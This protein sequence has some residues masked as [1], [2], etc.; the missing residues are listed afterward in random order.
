MHVLVTVTS[1]NKQTEITIALISERLCNNVIAQQN[2]FP[3]PISTTA[4][5][6]PNFKIA[7]SLWFLLAM[8]QGSVQIRRNRAGRGA[9]N[10][11]VSCDIQ[12]GNRQTTRMKKGR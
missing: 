8:Q 9:E 3:K 11:E 12:T 4:K 7:Y 10:V 2:P 6:R 5:V 1:V